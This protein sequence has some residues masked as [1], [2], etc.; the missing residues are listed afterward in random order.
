YD[1]HISEL[2][3]K[4]KLIE[5]DIYDWKNGN[6]NTLLSQLDEARRGIEE[7]INTSEG[8]K[9]QFIIDMI[10]DIEK[11]ENEIYSRIDEKISEAE[12]KLASVDE[13]LNNAI[14]NSLEEI[15]NR[16][17]ESVAKY[18][19]EIKRIEHHRETETE[20]IISDIEDLGNSIREDYEEYSIMIDKIYEDAVSEL[21]VHLE[22]IKKEIERA[23]S[24]AEEKHLSN[25]KNYI[26]DYLLNYSEKIEAHV[27]DKLSILTES[28]AQ[29]D[30]MIKESFNTL[31]SN[32]NDAMNRFN[33]EAN[34]QIH[35]VVNRLEKEAEERLNNDNKYISELEEQLR[36]I[37]V[38]IDNELYNISS[39]LDNEI[40][41]VKTKYKDLS[42]D[43]DEALDMI[44]ASILDRDELMELHNSE[45]EI[46][47]EQMETL[48][49]EFDSF[50][51]ELLKANEED[52]PT[53]FEEEKQK[54]EKA[55][56]D[57][58]SN[59]LDRMN[60][61]END[62]NY[63]KDVIVENRNAFLEK[64][65]NIKR[66]IE[67]IKDDNTI[68]QLALDKQSLEDSF[69]T[70]KDDFGKLSDLETALYQLRDNVEDIDLNFKDDIKVL[71][72]RFEE[73]ENKAVTDERFDNL[74]YS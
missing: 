14:G 21:E 31:N 55:F 9:N 1:N 20:N 70:I 65:D 36:A 34:T 45:K 15:H 69:N 53:L 43:F 4:M 7:F 72:E 64:I 30:D 48:K 11:K 73:F 2:K 16:I 33:E 37:S 58:T 17:N 52:I 60:N 62:I 54:I 35:S 68:A 29:L 59:L 56:E 39:K 71:S 8:K 13:K 23:R 3:E 24:E 5:Q 44:K 6:L 28:K 19:E 12:N 61:S 63:V 18:D 66:D 42:T 25:E 49:T 74:S 50:K 57:F 67:S 32:L 41:D 38:K 47:S 27:N 10:N 22:N 46:L 51:D 26:D 40:S